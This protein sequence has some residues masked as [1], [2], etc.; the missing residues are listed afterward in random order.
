MKENMA[1][2]AVAVA[3]DADDDAVDADEGGDGSS[4]ESADGRQS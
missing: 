2:D 1:V 4:D 3:V